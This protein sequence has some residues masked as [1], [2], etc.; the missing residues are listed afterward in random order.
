[1]NKI[2]YFVSA[3]LFSSSIYAQKEGF[4]WSATTDIDEITDYYRLLQNLY[5]TKVK[6]PL[7]P[8]E[9]FLKLSQYANGKLLVV[10]KYLQ[11][12][13]VKL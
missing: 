2:V 1:M 4:E 10:K 5:R 7:F 6:R 8:L 3:V 11:A 9:F 12:T 13:P